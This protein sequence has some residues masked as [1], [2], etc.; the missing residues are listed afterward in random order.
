LLE[1]PEV[2]WGRLPQDLPRS[3]RGLLERC[4]SA[5]PRQR[6]QAI[7]EARIAL[8]H[9]LAGDEEGGE[10]APAPGRRGIPW[11]SLA[12]AVLLTAIGVWWLRPSP[13]AGLTSVPRQQLQLVVHPEA[14]SPR[15][16]PDGSRVVYTQHE[17]L[18]IY[19]LAD[20]GTR[21]IEGVERVYNPAWS[22]DGTE[23]A[24]GHD[25]R[26]WR[27][28]LDGS[29]PAVVGDMP[30]GPLYI[31]WGFPDRI[32]ISAV[33][34]L[35]AMAPT[36]GAAE[37]MMPRES[38]ED[39]LIDPHSTPAGAV[40][41]ATADRDR[42][43]AWIDGERVTVLESEGAGFRRPH[44]V[45]GG[46]IVYVRAGTNPGI[47]AVRVDER[48]RP[49]GAPFVAEPSSQLPTVSR[50]GQIVY[51]RR[52]V[53]QGKLVRVSRDGVVSPT[54]SPSQTGLTN[55]EVLPSGREALVVA[56]AAG[57]TVGK[58]WLHSLD[59]GAAPR[60]LTVDTDSYDRYPIASPSGHLM[61]YTSDYRN[62]RYLK[63]ATLDRPDR[64]M[65]V[66]EGVI[67]GSF[68]ADGQAVV[69]VK[70]D[71]EHGAR[72]WIASARG[73]GEPRLL[74]GDPEG[75]VDDPRISPDGRWLAY[76]GSRFNRP[77][78]LVSGFPDGSG[79]WQVTTSGAVE[80]R[81]SP[82]G[83]ELYYIADRT[84]FAVPV[85]TGSSMFAFG[86]P[87]ALFD[88]GSLGLR[89]TSYVPLPDGSGFLMVRTDIGNEPAEQEAM[90]LAQGW[91]GEARDAR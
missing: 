36:G 27:L 64:E 69:Y 67:R 13:G 26:M 42:I 59:G 75:G 83:D 37:L 40:L 68:S 61:L 7:G 15:I 46:F 50:N 32:V 38:A 81:W 76:V 22:P 25:G 14:G 6:L 23:I 41:F 80:P 74:F 17:R 82:D 10:P 63:L 21:A 44:W 53:L 91:Q 90:V 84:L 77:Q 87:V 1:N 28:G 58:L 56:A 55:P 78:V 2:D 52:A 47:W 11:W 8:D 9:A 24:Y 18:W 62:V 45:E 4:L 73:D 34:G 20:L 70:R 72:M 49:I 12:A 85:Q 35:F 31:D 71:P 65:V 51:I 60:P 57:G 79:P 3:V 86:E 43:D 48:L 5:D 66:D 39:R 16:S 54:A 88:P 33:E 89:P 29:R 30:R 19:S